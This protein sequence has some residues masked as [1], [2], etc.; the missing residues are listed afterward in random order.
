VDRNFGP[1]L[2]R[3]DPLTGKALW[4]DERL[5]GT[6]TV[7]AGGVAFDREAVYCASGG[8][9]SAHAL[10]DGEELWRV[11]LP[12]GGRAWQV[13]PTR[14]ALVVY[15]AAA[16]A[17]DLLCRSCFASLTLAAAFPLHERMTVG[18]PVLC[19]DPQ[20]GRLIERLNLPGAGPEVAV[21][22]G[23]RAGEPLLPQLRLGEPPVRLQVSRRG[24]VAATVG[25]V[26]GRAS[27]A[28]E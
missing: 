9:L 15:P 4:P 5:L 16:G 14:N 12:A 8:V 24:I 1:T 25:T 28:R 23:F 18:V 21:R 19:C 10:A 17:R 13:L 11:R 27:T 3:L 7:P 26:A 20:T 22:V 2:Q 6:E